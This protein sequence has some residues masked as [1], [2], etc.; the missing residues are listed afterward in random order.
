M[1]RASRNP[2]M[3]T[4]GFETRRFAVLLNQRQGRAPTV[5]SSTCGTRRAR[6]ACSQPAERDARYGV[7]TSVSWVAFATAAVLNGH[8]RVRCV[9]QSGV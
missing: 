2:R 6:S 1:P 5:C 9:C 3:R 7:S 8:G 4:A